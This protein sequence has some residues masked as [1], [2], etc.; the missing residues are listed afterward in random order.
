MVIKVGTVWTLRQE[1]RRRYGGHGHTA[2]VR[3]VS[4]R[5]VVVEYRAP[6][7]YRGKFD[8]LLKGQFHHDFVSRR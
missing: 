2:L 5:G 4:T 8:Y 1:I 3:K 6:A 7:R